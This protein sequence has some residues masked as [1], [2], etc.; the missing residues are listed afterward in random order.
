VAGSTFTLDSGRATLAIMAPE[1]CFGQIA[2]E[3][4]TRYAADKPH[5][6][7]VPRSWDQLSAGEQNAWDAAGLSVVREV[8]ERTAKNAAEWAALR[9]ED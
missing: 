3:G 7:V 2:F 6:R 1:K 8:E 9:G 4:F 5:L